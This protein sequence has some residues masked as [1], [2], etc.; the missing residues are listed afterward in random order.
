MTGDDLLE[1][2]QPSTAH[3]LV[4]QQPHGAALAGFHSL[5]Q[6]GHLAPVGV[7]ALQEPAAQR[8]ASFP[9]CR[10]SRRLQVLILSHLTH[11]LRPI[12]SSGE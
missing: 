2:A 9:P 4:V 8:M 7:L 11:Q 12:T 10:H 6:L 3:L 1:E 5:A